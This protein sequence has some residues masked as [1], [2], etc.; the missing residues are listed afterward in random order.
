ML[1]FPMFMWISYDV[2]R[3]DINKDED[4]LSRYSL[5][6]VI[7]L[8]KNSNS[9]LIKLEPFVTYYHPFY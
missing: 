4:G 1:I 2:R 3:Q 6:L 9:N 7:N 5:F 8:H